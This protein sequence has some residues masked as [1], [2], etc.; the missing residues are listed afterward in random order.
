MK[1]RFESHS[2]LLDSYMRIKHVSCLRIILRTM[3]SIILTA[4]ATI[5]ST[6]AFAQ[7][8]RI[9]SLRRVIETSKDDTIRSGA[10][11]GLCW[12]LL[13]AGKLEEALEK[14][15][16]G[17]A[18]CRK[19]EKPEF[20]ALCHLNVGS[21]YFSQGDYTNAIANYKQSLDVS[22][23][24]GDRQGMAKASGN[25]GNVYCNQGDFAKGLAN[26]QLSL[27][28]ME[29]TGEEDVAASMMNNI[30]MV[31]DSQ[32]DNEHAFEYFQK[33]LTAARKI[34]NA[35]LEAISL[36]NIG[37]SLGKQKKYEEGLQ[38]LLQSVSIKE[39]AGD[40]P[41]VALNLNN[42]GNIYSKLKDNQK[43]IETFKRALTIAQQHKIKR[44]EALSLSNLSTSYFDMRQTQAAKSAAENGLKVAQEIGQLEYK[45]SSAY[46]LY[47][48]D[49]ALANWK[50]AF[51]SHRLYKIYSDSMKNDDQSKELGRL[52]S[53]YAFE[54]QAEEEKRLA[55]EAARIEAEQTERRNNLQ[56]LSIFAALI[57]LFGALVFMGRFQVP[58]RLMEVA[59]FAGLLIVFEFLLVLFDPI[60][61]D[62]S[63]GAPV[64]KLI[65]NTCIA[66]IFAPLH[67]FSLHKLR[68]RLVKSIE[69][70]M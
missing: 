43:A 39:K 7:S 54:K 44:A 61:D 64:Y 32:D 59:L 51:E 18:L 70:D 10:L 17:I 60:V 13:N 8:P 45:K 49:S 46:A 41:F 69:K 6:V 35:N 29:E 19:S 62:F 58:V 67:H 66:I 36:S 1:N 38:N 26:F 31:Y 3:K 68:Q 12:N 28:I 52:E 55:E 4:L 53:K 5:L 57:A 2:I 30:G 21:V 33:C 14:G 42:I 15:K 24:I 16:E 50:A 47:R 27:K 37:M 65:F 48:A 23:R 34:G 40:W 56:Y 9:D 22:E 20:E 11:C 25:L 63:G